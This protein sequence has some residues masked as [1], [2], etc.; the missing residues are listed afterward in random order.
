MKLRIVVTLKTF[1][2]ISIAVLLFNFGIAIFWLDP[3][4][5]NSGAFALVWSQ[6]LFLIYHSGLYWL[7]PIIF[8][9]LARFF[10]YKKSK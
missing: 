6:F 4:K 9:T 5:L 7:I 10:V 1:L 3:H 2:T 8:F